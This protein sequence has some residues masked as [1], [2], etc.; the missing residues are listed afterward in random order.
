[1]SYESVPPEEPQ[2]Y[3]AMYNCI[4]QLTPRL[5]SI[6]RQRLKGNSPQTIADPLGVTRERVRQLVKEGLMSLRKCLCLGM[7]VNLP[8]RPDSGA[9][10][11][12]ATESQGLTLNYQHGLFGWLHQRRR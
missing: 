10:L 9:L 11:I 8:P 12:T 3:T 6:I 7:A 4:D 1:M 5:A 2:N